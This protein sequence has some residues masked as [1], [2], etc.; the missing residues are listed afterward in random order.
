[1]INAALDYV[2]SPAAIT[3]AKDALF[4]CCLILAIACLCLAQ[5]LP[6]RKDR[7]GFYP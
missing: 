2:T 7:G 6:R 5:P 1:M 3:F 4:G